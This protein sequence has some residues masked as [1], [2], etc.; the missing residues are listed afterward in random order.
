METWIGIVGGPLA[1]K[2]HALVFGP[3][4]N[5]INLVSVA[6]VAALAVIALEDQ[7]LRGETLEIGGPENVGFRDARQTVD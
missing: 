3:G 6:D 2:G 5:P 1:D 7:T 4:K